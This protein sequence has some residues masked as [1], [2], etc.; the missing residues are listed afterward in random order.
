MG[1]KVVPQRPGIPLMYDPT[2]LRRVRRARGIEVG[3]LALTAGLSRQ[4]IS[5]LERGM[6]EPKA[7]T[8]ALLARALGVEIGAFFGPD[9]G[10]V[11]SR[12]CPDRN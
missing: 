1:R 3:E 2:A 6:T 9:R 8:L 4:A 7:R 10:S 5:Y 12:Q 11:T